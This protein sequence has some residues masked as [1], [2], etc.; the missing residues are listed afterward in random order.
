MAA[1]GSPGLSV[2]HTPVRSLGELPALQQQER[3]AQRRRS[4]GSRTASLGSG[5]EAGAA[6]KRQLMAG[7]RAGWLVG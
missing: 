4:L 5:I 6:S 1:Q 3:L 2:L 7:A